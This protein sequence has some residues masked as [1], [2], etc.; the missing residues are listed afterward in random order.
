MTDSIKPDPDYCG[1]GEANTGPNDPWWKR[2]CIPHDTAYQAL[3]EKKADAGPYRVFGTFTKNIAVGMAQ[4]AFML[5]TGP[6]YWL[7]GG[8]GGIF[9]YQQL[10]NRANPKD[11][12]GEDDVLGDDV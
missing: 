10:E 5:L 1:L 3:I 7:I 6:L 9:R 12:Q 4:G 8:V 11:S 2:A